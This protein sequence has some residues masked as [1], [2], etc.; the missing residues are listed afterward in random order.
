MQPPAQRHKNQLN[1]CGRQTVE[2]EVEVEDKGL[3]SCRYLGLRRGPLPA[4]VSK[5][6]GPFHRPNPPGRV[7][8]AEFHFHLILIFKYSN[9]Q[10]LTEK[11]KFSFVKIILI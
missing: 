1:D 3:L 6:L 5:H 8:I 10:I 11:N 9:I 2:V 4:L 7:L